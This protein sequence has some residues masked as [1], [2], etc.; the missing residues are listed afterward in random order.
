MSGKST[1]AVIAASSVTT[2]LLGTFQ[3]V[4][5]VIVMGIAGGV[6]HFT[7]YRK[8][9]RLG[10]VVISHYR[11]IG[12]RE[13]EKPYIYVYKTK[14]SLKTFYPADECLL[15]IGEQL[16]RQCVEQ[17]QQRSTTLERG[18]EGEDQR[19]W[20]RYLQEALS[21]LQRK[22]EFNFERPD[23][24][25]DKL[26]LDLDNE[27]VIEISH[28][29]GSSTT[30]M[31]KDSFRLHLGAIGGGS[32]TS[33]LANTNVRSDFAKKYGLLATD[34]GMNTILEAIIGNCRDSFILVKG[35][36][37]YSLRYFWR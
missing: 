22:T 4:T 17:Q 31:A 12:H 36:L 33:M 29:I 24:N 23:A 26:Y 1:E 8:H 10:D 20:E 35:K 21:V 37:F 3:K 9:V 11:E 6:P 5:H 2:R 28:P 25:T 7:D 13:R 19:P 32:T 30:Q 14:D 16:Y 18:M 15:K 27:D 34:T